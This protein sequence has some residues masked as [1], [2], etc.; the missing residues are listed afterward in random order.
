MH[1]QKEQLRSGYRLADLPRRIDP[2]QQ[3]HGDIQHHDIRPKLAGSRHQRSSI[4]RGADQVIILFEQFLEPIEQQGMIV[5]Q[6]HAGPAQDFIGGA[7]QCHD[8]FSFGREH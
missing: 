4:G 1:R 6:Q 2:I 7:F 5:G 3:R 8:D